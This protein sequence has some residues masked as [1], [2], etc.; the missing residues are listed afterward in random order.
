MNRLFL[1][2]IALLLIGFTSATFAQGQPMEGQGRSP[3]ERAKN[4]TTRMTKQFG[5]STEQQSSVY[6]VNLN[7][8]KKV[9]EMRGQGK[10]MRQQKVEQMKQMR[11]E[12]EERM[13][14][15]LTPDQF[16]SY[17]KMREENQAKRREKMQE[18]RAAGGK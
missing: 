12:H 5:L 18:R 8:A 4:L 7:Q 13:K 15:I 10:E 9:E 6:E 16:T 14:V 3:E 1:L 17:V 2:A 11:T